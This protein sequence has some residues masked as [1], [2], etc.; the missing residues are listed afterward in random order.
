MPHLLDAN[1]LI[2][3]VNRNDPQH[4]AVRRALR[5]PQWSER[6]RQ[7]VEIECPGCHRSAE[8]PLQWQPAAF[9]GEPVDPVFG[10]QLWLQAP[11]CGHV[12]WAYNREHLEVIRGYVT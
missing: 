6:Q 11:C 8:L 1:I 7:T 5:R 2:R 3:Y 10:L 4:R 12:L 9:T